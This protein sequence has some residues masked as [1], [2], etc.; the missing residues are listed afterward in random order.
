MLYTFIAVIHVS[1]LVSY[2]SLEI[3]DLDIFP[4]YNVTIM[5]IFYA[6]LLIM[7]AIPLRG[8]R[9]KNLDVVIL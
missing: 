6:S 7:L 2:H 1:A 9:R 4:A 3:I 5:I 8:E